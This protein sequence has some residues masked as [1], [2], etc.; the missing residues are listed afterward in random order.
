MF[1]LR[2]WLPL[3]FIPT[4]ASPAFIVLFLISTYLFHRPCV[5]CSLIM[6]TLFSSSCYWSD[7]CFLDSNNGHWFEPRF[8]STA[9]G[10][11]MNAAAGAVGSSGG[12]AIQ[13]GASAG[14]VWTGIGLDW[15]RTAVGRR[16]WRLPCVDVNIRL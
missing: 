4:S 2:S 10:T 8:L 16:E 9:A 7:R 15:L 3:L 12:A 5:Y 14:Q 1:C 6:L 13:A 11:V